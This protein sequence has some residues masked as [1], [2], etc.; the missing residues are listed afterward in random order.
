MTEPFLS[1]AQQLANQAL[2]LRNHGHINVDK[3]IQIYEI[4]RYQEPNSTYVEYLNPEGEV[5]TSAIDLPLE[6]VVLEASQIGFE[7][8]ETADQTWGLTESQ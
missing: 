1:N 3:L 5:K 2:V 6:Q 4:Q 8:E 7:Q